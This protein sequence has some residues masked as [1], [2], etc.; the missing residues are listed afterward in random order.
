MEGQ[1]QPN[2]WEIVVPGVHSDLGCGYSPKEQGKGTLDNGTDMLSRIP[3]AIMYKMARLAGVP[4]K[5]EHASEAAKGR[6]VIQKT[7]IEHLNN[8]LAVCKVKSG[9]LTGIMR[10]QARLQMEWR[11]SRRSTGKTPIERT[12]FYSRSNML[13]KNDF[14]SAF[15]EFER[16]IADFEEWKGREG[17]DFAPEQQRSGFSNDHKSEWEE[18]ARWYQPRPTVLDAVAVMFDDYVHDSRS[19]F[20][21]ILGNPDSV[22][23]T[24][25][26]LDKLCF[27]RDEGARLRARPANERH[28]RSP[29]H[30]GRMELT[31]EELR[32]ANAYTTGGK[33]IPPM[34]TEGREP[35]AGKNRAGYL[36][37]RKIYG[38]K[39]SV[40]L[41]SEPAENDQQGV[42]SFVS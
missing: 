11:L 17:K 4:L 12:Q 42:D 19:W 31:P 2:W 23:G 10:E 22:K 25:E 32:L 8:Y 6:F 35:Y 41:S 26:K 28:G 15:L 1:L 38:G 7:T 21:I 27:K 24:K 34:I 39:D 3:L 14:H 30:D 9:S 33:E 18:I 40:L 36:R 20:K 29:R 37:Y 16:E 13:D 5:L